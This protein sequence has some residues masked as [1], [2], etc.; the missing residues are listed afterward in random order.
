MRVFI[1]KGI[2]AAPRVVAGRVGG[3]SNQARG[4]LGTEGA[5]RRF[6]VSGVA[7]LSFPVLALSSAQL[8]AAHKHV[9]EGEKAGKQGG[10]MSGCNT[11]KEGNNIAHCALLPDTWVAFRT[12]SDVWRTSFDGHASVLSSYDLIPLRHCRGR[13]LRHARRGLNSCKQPRTHSRGGGRTKT[14]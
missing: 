13:L 8:A 2:C 11:L 4:L 7:G 3:L 10:C 5:R 14:T 1:T 9:A 12:R 6:T